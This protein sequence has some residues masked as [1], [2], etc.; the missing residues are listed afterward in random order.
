MSV[1]LLRPRSAATW[2]N[3]FEHSGS[4]CFADTEEVAMVVTCPSPPTSGPGRLLLAA[5][6]GTRVMNRVRARAEDR[7]RAGEGGQ[8]R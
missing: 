7:A 4:L 8:K 1:S 5:I 6:P 2:E 3:G